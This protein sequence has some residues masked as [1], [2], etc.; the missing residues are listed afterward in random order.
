MSKIGRALFGFGQ[1]FL[2]GRLIQWQTERAQQ[3]E[4]M[5]EQRLRQ[6]AKEDR[7]EE[8][9][10]QTKRETEANQRQ[11]N[12]LR[13]EDARNARRDALEEKNVNSQISARGVAAQQAAAELLLRDLAAGSLVES[14]SEPLVASTDDDRERTMVQRQVPLTQLAKG[15]SGKLVPKPVA[16]RGGV[17]GMK[18]TVP[19]PNGSRIPIV[20]PNGTPLPAGFRDQYGEDPNNVAG[21]AT[22]AQRFNP[23]QFRA[24]PGG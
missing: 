17:Q 6:Y 2:Q 12:R 16:S 19:G 7:G 11:D 24:T 3:A 9:A 10:F 15:V 18:G 8:R 20:I 21:G 13:T 22:G 5:K 4:L 14:E 23:N 1:G